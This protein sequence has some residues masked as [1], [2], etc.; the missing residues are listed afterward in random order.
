LSA[1]KKNS[2]T[3]VFGDVSAYSRYAGNHSSGYRQNLIRQN[4]FTSF[5]QLSVLKIRSFSGMCLSFCP[6][7]SL[8]RSAK[9]NISSTN[10][11]VCNFTKISPPF[12][13]SVKFET[14]VKD[15]QSKVLTDTKFSK[16]FLG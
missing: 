12:A 3:N 13:V 7:A 6:S 8:H 11:T 4:R 9:L 15:I 16:I 5:L 10:V 14:Q 1:W 2:A